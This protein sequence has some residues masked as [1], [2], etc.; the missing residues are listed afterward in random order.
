MAA[1]MALTRPVNM[2]SR[3][4]ARMRSST[5]RPPSGSPSSAVT[6]PSCSWRKN[7]SA[8][9]VSVKRRATN[10]PA[11]NA[12]NA[13]SRAIRSTK[14]CRMRCMRSRISGGTAVLGA[15]A[16]AGGAD[17]RGR[18]PGRR[19]GRAADPTPQAPAARPTA[20]GRRQR[21][22][23][24]RAPVEGA[25]RVG[26]ERMPRRLAAE[27]PAQ[28]RGDDAPLMGRHVDGVAA[29][30]RRG[31]HVVEREQ[32][33]IRPRRLDAEDVERGAAEMSAAQG[34]GQRRLVDERR[35]RRVDQARARPHA[36]Q[37]RGADHA[38]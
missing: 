32:R 30:V 22:W 23:A 19:R 25:Q 17:G 18:A 13:A 24:R 21:A 27:Q 36:C 20:R 29:D 3:I 15:V 1:C 5:S 31:D 28:L 11:A 16:G 12:R 26:I 9:S 4:S 38:P 33:V 37:R 7:A 8:R 35:A 34:V 2:P 6:A 10:F 14:P